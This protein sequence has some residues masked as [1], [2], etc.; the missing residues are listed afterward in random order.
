MK[1]VKA[2]FCWFT[3][4]FRESRQARQ[5]RS[6][7]EF[8]KRFPCGGLSWCNFRPEFDGFWVNAWSAIDPQRDAAATR[9]SALELLANI[10]QWLRDHKSDFEPGDVIQLIVGFDAS[11]KSSCRQIFKCYV[12]AGRLA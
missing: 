5:E 12:P 1:I 9:E 8:C 6:T 4:P 10:A 7:R 11:V 2:V 3:W